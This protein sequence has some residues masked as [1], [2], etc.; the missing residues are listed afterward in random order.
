MTDTID[1]IAFMRLAMSNIADAARL[2]DLISEEHHRR[3]KNAIWFQDFDPE[4]DAI[5]ALTPPVASVA[6]GVETQ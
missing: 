5:P 1:A 4:D 3:I 6:S 2:Q